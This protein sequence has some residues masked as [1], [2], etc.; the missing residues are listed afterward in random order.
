[1]A[2]ISPPCEPEH[3]GLRL[4]DERATQGRPA[5]RWQKKLHRTPTACRSP[6]SHPQGQS[7]ARNDMWHTRLRRCA[8]NSA[9]RCSLAS[10]TVHAAGDR[11]RSIFYDTVRLR[12]LCKT[13][14]M[15]VRVQNGKAGVPD[16]CSV[17]R[18]AHAKQ[19]VRQRPVLGRTPAGA[20]LGARVASLRVQASRPGWPWH[21]RLSNSITPSHA[22]HGAG[23]A[24]PPLTDKLLKPTQSCIAAPPWP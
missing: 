8:S 6:R 15:R 18:A 20:R 13:P 23:F 7:C 22:A 24:E 4:L 2:G 16:W 11:A 5:C 21:S 14:A 9:T 12:R 1:L 10:E 19:R 17:C 3:C